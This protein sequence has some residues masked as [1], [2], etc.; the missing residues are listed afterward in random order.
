MSSIVILL[1]IVLFLAMVV[2]AI[3]IYIFVVMLRV[4]GKRGVL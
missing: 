4:I 1:K 3:S 2:L